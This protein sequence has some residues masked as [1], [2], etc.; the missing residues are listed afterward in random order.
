L[1]KGFALFHWFQHSFFPNVVSM[2]VQII[3]GS[4]MQKTLCLCGD[5]NPQVPNPQARPESE[6]APSNEP[7]S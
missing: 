5:G 3:K 7:L 6:R 2:F 4:E 1:R